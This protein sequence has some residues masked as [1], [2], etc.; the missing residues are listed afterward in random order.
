MGYASAYNPRPVKIILKNTKTKKEFT[1]TLKA[2]PQFWFSG[3]HHIKESVSLPQ[4][5]SAGNYQLYLYLP[6]A[7]VLL[8]GRPEYCVQLCNENMWEAFTGYNNLH[9]SIQIK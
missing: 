6:D 1:V 3:I 2:N 4:K 9:H 5:I 7:N 8:A